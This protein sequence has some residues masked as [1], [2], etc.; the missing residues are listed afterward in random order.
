MT[1]A[2]ATNTTQETAPS[3]NTATT[4]QVGNAGA[5]NQ[6]TSASSAK[7]Q[8]V[9]DKLEGVTPEFDADII[10]DAEKLGLSVDQAKAYRAYE[11]ERA[12]ASDAQLAKEEA[13][14]KAQFEQKRAQQLQEW[15]KAAREHKEYGGD[16]YDETNIRID[17]VIAEYGGEEMVKEI[18]NA[19]A[20]KNL[21]VFR[22]FLAKIAYAH[23]E[24]SFVKG[25]PKQDAPQSDAQLFYRKS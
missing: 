16:K 6:N 13:E 21:P 5:T 18:A 19:P 10:K 8:Y 1:E 12:K 4:T 23:S 15:E 14:H 9:F 7:I 17:K 22:N 25:S 11:F 3:T 2:V 20:L 24:G